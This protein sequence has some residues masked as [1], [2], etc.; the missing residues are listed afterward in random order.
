MGERI[1]L[2]EFGA[3]CRRDTDFRKPFA[4]R[5]MCRTVP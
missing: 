2:F 3:A 1:L 4:R 5:V